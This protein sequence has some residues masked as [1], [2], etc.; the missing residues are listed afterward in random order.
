M[1]NTTV[2]PPQNHT[3]TGAPPQEVEDAGGLVVFV[4]ML[5]LLVGMG[6]V[7]LLR[8]RPAKKTEK[9]VLALVGVS[10]FFTFS[11]VYLLPLDLDVQVS[12]SLQG[13]WRAFYWINFLSMWIVFPLVSC[14]YYAGEFNWIGKWKYALKV[15]LRFYFIMIVIVIIFII[16]L[17]AVD[18]HTRTSSAVM[19]FGKCL[20]NLY[21]LVVALLLLGYGLVALPRSFWRHSNR[22]YTQSVLE[23]TVFHVHD[24]LNEAQ[25]QVLLLQSM[26]NGLE[27]KLMNSNNANAVALNQHMDTVRDALPDDQ[28]V[29]G[30]TLTDWSTIERQRAEEDQMKGLSKIKELTSDTIQEK[31]LA[32]LHMYLKA[33]V[34]LVHSLSIQLRTAID[35]AIK[36]TALVKLAEQPRPSLRSGLRNAIYWR[37]VCLWQPKLSKAVAVVTGLFSVLL[38]WSEITLAA[39]G[40]MSPFGAWIDVTRGQRVVN[41]IVALI[42]WSYMCAC[43]FYSMYQVKAGERYDLHKNNAT[44]TSSLIRNAYY[45]ARF[46]GPLAA[47]FL[48]ATN[49]S[50]T[51]FQAV[52]G[53]MSV[54]SVFGDIFNEYLP[55]TLVVLML[56]TMMGWVGRC[57]KFLRLT[58]DQGDDE[59]GAEADRAEGRRIIERAERSEALSQGGGE[60]AHSPPLSDGG[61][62]KK[63]GQINFTPSSDADDDVFFIEKRNR[64]KERDFNVV[65]MRN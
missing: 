60:S 9:V 15:N 27:K 30:K 28:D 45:T 8:T 35:Q 33:K 41:Q 48:S 57:L 6:V 25:F 22:T 7:H 56:V 17:V 1:P 2:A 40:Q 46:I 58:N 3:T 49:Q 38:L 18:P 53:D 47:N 31:H 32:S 64:K 4:L 59:A 61:K 63:K 5:M 50:H 29:G 65:E 12:G 44:G 26:F 23:S 11:Y 42:P 13:A 62:K 20:S 14:Y 24:K 36:T 21:G 19:G 43:A 16:V 51:G 52:L 10:W 39:P 34:F 55:L 37:Y 54:A